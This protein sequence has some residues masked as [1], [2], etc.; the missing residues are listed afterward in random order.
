MIAKIKL[1]LFWREYRK[2]AQK[3]HEKDKQI[4]SL[5]I[6]VDR[7]EHD[8]MVLKSKLAKVPEP[9]NA[10][11]RAKNWWADRKYGNKYP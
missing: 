5:N 2:F 7:L 8:K 4:A 1:F 10:K 9:R 3:L 11:D 6:M